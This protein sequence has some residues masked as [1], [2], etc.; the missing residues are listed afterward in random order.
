MHSC[1]QYIHI[2]LTFNMQNVKEFLFRKEKEFLLIIFTYTFLEIYALNAS[3]ANELQ[4]LHQKKW[5]NKMMLKERKK[6]INNLNKCLHSARKKKSGYNFI[7]F[8]LF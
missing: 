4:I 6:G 5:E 1:I 3:K 8:F 7:K 2:S